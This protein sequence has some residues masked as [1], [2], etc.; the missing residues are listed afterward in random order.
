VPAWRHWQSV[1][2]QW[3]VGMAGA[4]GLRY[5]G[6]RAYLQEAGLRGAQR[7]DAWRG[8]C[9]CEAAT[10]AAWAKQRAQQRA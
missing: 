6:V 3:N 2:T 10:L 9:V 1:Q 8:I 7:Q 5:E 4:T